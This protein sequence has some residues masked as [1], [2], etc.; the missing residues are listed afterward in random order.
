MC[1]MKMKNYVAYHVHD[2]DSLLDSCTK[3]KDYVNK[4]VELGQTAIAITNHGNIFNW[5][6]RKI[7]AESKGIKMLMGIECYVTED[8]CDGTQTQRHRDNYHTIL[9]AKNPDGEKE[10]CRL[11][12]T[13]SLPSH[14]F[15]DNRITVDELCGISDN[16]YKISACLASPLNRLRNNPDKH[17][18]L[19]TLLKTYDYYE[20]QPHN[21]KEQIEYNQWLYSMSKKY[22]K[23]LI[24]GTDT[25]SLNEYKS[26]CTTILKISK[27][28][29]TTAEDTF[30]LTYKSYSELVEM[31][32][33]QNAIPKEEWLKAI[34]NTN[35]MAEAVVPSVVD[36]SVKYPNL[37][38]DKTLSVFKKRIYDMYTDKV[39]RGIIKPSKQWIERIKEELDVFVK[40]DYV[41]F[42]LF[43]SEMAEWCW[44]NGIPLGFCRGSVGGSGIAYILDIIDVNVLKWKTVFSRF[45][46]VTRAKTEVGD[47]DL[48][49]SPS[50][51]RLVQEY[52]M[53]RFGTDYTAY[54]L[55]IGTIADLGCIDDIGRALAIK[56]E[57]GYTN[58]D[59][60]TIIKENRKTSSS[61]PFSL[62]IISRIKEEYKNNPEQTKTKYPEIFFYFD[63]LLNTNVSQSM[64][65]AGVIASPISLTDNYGTFWNDGKHILALNMEECHELQLAKYDCLGLK[66]IEIIKDTCE[67]AGIPYPKSYQMDWEDKKVWKHITDSPV[68]IF[69]F[70]GDY[71]FKLLKAYQPKMI[72]H[73]STINA[74]LR[75]SGE[76]YRDKLISHEKCINPSPIID[77]LLKDNDGFLIFQEDTIKF[78]TD[79]CGLSGAEADNV[80][81]AIGRKQLDRLQEALPRIL[82]GYCEK[83]D[84]PREIAEKEAQQFLQIIQDSA[85]YQFGYNHSTGYSM[86]GY[87]CAYLRYYYPVEF[88]TA[89]LQNAKDNEDIK[90]GTELAKQLGIK[91]S[92]IKFRHSSDKYTCD[93]KNKIVYKSISSIKTFG[94]DM[95]VTLDKIK[96]MKFDTFFDYLKV[97]PCGKATEVLIKLNFFSEFGKSARLLKMYELFTKFYGKKQID[98]TNCTGNIQNI[99]ANTCTKETEKR[100]NFKDGLDIDVLNL[101][102]SDIENKSISLT[103]LIEIQIEYYGYIDYKNPKSPEGLYYVTEFKTYK[104]KCKPY[105][106]L[107]H[108]KSGTTEKSKVVDSKI[109]VSSPFE[110]GSILNVWFDER[111][112]SKFDETKKKWIKTNETEKIM[113]HWEVIK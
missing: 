24:A 58:T 3:Y 66:N 62:P 29:L 99:I 107:Y 77:E 94:K 30:D 5:L 31:F 2:D 27:K 98:K 101:M 7:Y 72:T 69:Q 57:A 79:I 106:T 19:D 87:T 70:E 16:V 71:A 112:K 33:I 73:L 84:Q 85:N 110:Q 59:I 15:Y 38:G 11:F 113:A 22:N 108:F 92:N 45:C 100:Y 81:R 91:I 64:H 111:K 76:S 75:P 83:S 41:G 68:G 52:I 56:W 104:D 82:D 63:G 12:D 103:E 18:L 49:I 53:D 109:F 8:K 34:D 105:V 20:I 43:M 36:H 4:A 51:R 89:Y 23:P 88:V 48:D 17:K 21:I 50:Q 74:S 86:I 55:S 54:V 61:N 40:V 47:I 60:K 97:N 67:L 13:S 93:T 65:P 90:Q 39:K 28:I 96:D 80:R 46:N 42:M 25:H 1:N 32:E 9:I 35:V 95:A 10:I 14:F 6:E 102:T 26:K 78:L 44:N 37:Y